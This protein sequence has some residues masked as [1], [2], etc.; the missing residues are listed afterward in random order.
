MGNYLNFSRMKTKMLLRGAVV[1][2]VL[3][4]GLALFA[5]TS[6][7]SCEGVV[8][9]QYGSPIEGIYVQSSVNPAKQDRTDSDGHYFLSGLPQNSTVEVIVPSGFS[10]SGSTVSQKLSEQSNIANFTLHDDGY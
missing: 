5:G 9:D 1:A 2:I 8:N 4:V 6:G 10:E 3:F 7:V